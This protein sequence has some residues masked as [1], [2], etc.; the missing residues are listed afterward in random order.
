MSPKSQVT[1]WVV[2]QGVVGMENQCLGLAAALGLDPVVK[3][4]RLRS[5]W[6]QLAPFLRCGLRWAFSKKGDPVVPPWPDLMICSGRAG[7]AAC[8]YVRRAAKAAGKKV[9]TVYIQNPV[10]DPSRFDLVAL[11]RHDG[12]LGENVVTTRGSLHRVT[13]EVLAAE[14]AKFEP[15]YA[16][17]PSP[18]LAVLIG[19]T[20]SV[21]Q[22]T[23]H[24]MQPL[25]QRLAELARET[26][27]SLMVTPSRRTGAENLAILTEALKDVPHIIWNGNGPNPY[28]AMLGLADT[29]LV[30]ADSVNM[31]S[32]S[33]STGK[34]VY[35]IPLSGGSEK[36]R[37]FHQAL[38]DDGMTRPFT[39]KLETWTY[40]PLNDVQLVANRVREMMEK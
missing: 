3:R 4:V 8:L 17:L 22:F 6:K 26:G 29:I 33:C 15:V 40:T 31:T 28:Y 39:G 21:Y 35:V 10:I 27:G 18:R 14:T 37:R 23:P 24:E 16:H 5:P 1:C 13:P 9:F 38:R 12:V 32:E 25:A 19:G 2:T 11:P 34:P 7:G 36:F 20:N 30:T